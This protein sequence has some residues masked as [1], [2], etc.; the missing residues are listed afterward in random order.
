MGPW[1]D[2]SGAGVCG[3]TASCPG[4][5]ICLRVE[6][7]MK[8]LRSRRCRHCDRRFVP[9]FRNAH[10]QRF[11]PDTVCQ[12]VSKRVSQR[13]WLRNPDNRNHFCGSGEVRRVREWRSAHP[14]YWRTPRKK[15]ALSQGSKPSEVEISEPAAAPSTEAGTL[16]DYCR[17]RTPM[18]TALI[19]RLSGCTLQEDIAGCAAQLVSAAQCILSRCQSG[20]S[21]LVQTSPAPQAHET[22]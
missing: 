10:H 5:A 22:G 12:G 1:A 9:D 13:R 18:L 16:Q 20:F 14:G 17:S 6:F 4:R 15:C 19:S 11:C 21:A 2:L 7:A 8:P 3:S